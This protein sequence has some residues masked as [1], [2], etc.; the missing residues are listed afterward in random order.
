MNLQ[1]IS[2]TGRSSIEETTSAL[3]TPTL[4][5]AEDVGHLFDTQCEC[6]QLS[7]GPFVGELTELHANAAVIRSGVF[8]R[9]FQLR[10]EIHDDTVAVAFVE[11]SESVLE[12]GRPWSPGALLV[13]NGTD[14][15]MSSLGESEMTWIDIDVMHVRES[16]RDSLLRAA[17]GRSILAAAAGQIFDDLRSYAAAAIQMCTADP[18]LLQNDSM[19]RHIEVEIVRRA[20]DAV[21]AA[22]TGSADVRR[23][24]KAFALV[25]RVERYMW[26]NVGEPLT[27]ERICATT[28]C[29]MRS[30][31]Y[32]F[33]DSFGLGPITYLKIRR[34]NAARRR[35]KE[36][37]GD[38]RIFDV[39]ADFGFWHMGHFSADYK[40]MF[41]TTA[42][43]TVAAA[44]AQGKRRH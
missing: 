22:G 3:R 36:T 5:D 35:L 17:H 19:R 33:K 34:L 41:G 20:V 26:E 37:Y 30:L 24:R 27:L 7:P 16:D 38:V 10:R 11:S 8:N 13:V 1:S 4:N 29:R 15:D 32:S 12:H 14:I 6:I 18:L 21:A 28:N 40:R 43:E 2:S 39:A 42:S 25:R 44:R 31:I 9:G 23:E